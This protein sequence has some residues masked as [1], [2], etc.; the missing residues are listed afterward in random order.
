MNEEVVKSVKS[1]MVNVSI[2][3]SRRSLSQGLIPILVV[4]ISRIRRKLKLSPMGLFF[5]YEFLIRLFSDY[6]LKLPIRV[7]EDLIR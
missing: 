3:I 6:K 4:K 7:S 1:Y 5:L 2:I